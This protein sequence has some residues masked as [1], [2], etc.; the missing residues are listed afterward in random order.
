MPEL[1]RLRR[2]GIGAGAEALLW[3]L[4]SAVFLS[5]YIGLFGRS[6]AAAGAHATVLL[7][8]AGGL[9]AV[10]LVLISALGTRAATLVGAVL[11]GSAF[12]ALLAYYITVIVGLSTW[13]RVATLPLLKG[14][15]RHIDQLSNVLEIDG[16]AVALGLAG[17]VCL[18]VS[19]IWY[20][21][22]RLEWLDALRQVMPTQTRPVAFLALLVCWWAIAY[23]W[24]S[25]DFGAA[26]EPL[27]ISFMYAP[28]GLPNLQS[29]SIVADAQVQGIEDAARR[30]YEPAANARHRNV[31]LVVVDALRADHMSIYGYGRETT[32]HLQQP[33]RMKNLQQAKVARAVCSESLC[34]LIALASSR[35]VHQFVQ[36]PVTLQDVLRHHGYKIHMVL[37]GDHVNFYD[38]RKAYGRVD[39]YVD[40]GML[41]GYA[42]DDRLIVEHVR[43]MPDW[44]GTPAMIQFHLMSTHCLGSRYQEYR[45]YLPTHNG[46]VPKAAAGPGVIDAAINYYD[47]GVLQMDGLL[48]R[49]IKLL[50]KKRY[51]DDALVVVVGDH[52]EYIGEHGRFG[53][54]HGVH[55]PVVRIPFLL[56]SFGYRPLEPFARSTASQ[57]DV[58]PTILRELGMP[59]PSTWSGVP[60]QIPLAERTTYFQQ[61]LEF[62]LVEERS[63]NFYWKYWFNKETGREFAYNLEIDPLERDNRIGTLPRGER[64]RWFRQ[65]GANLTLSGPT[66]NFLEALSP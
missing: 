66:R 50:S 30:D 26:D 62:G 14:Y 28:E 17:V 58:S 34:G 3:G 15:V 45:K 44:D 33:E 21:L 47:N 40:G 51:L 57:I 9:I 60:M 5:A 42:N 1:L 20:G 56:F 25:G 22:R 2:I 64:F 29:H 46:C 52:G 11:M 6:A 39:S 37:S 24:T 49:V 13:R 23:K 59:S 65:V 63:P 32:P 61:G 35:Y 48:D 36:Q 4:P 38:L 19:A 18:T 54:A 31:I 53:H 7:L 27:S 41:P 12:W 8:I 43:S 55:E 16:T 10:R